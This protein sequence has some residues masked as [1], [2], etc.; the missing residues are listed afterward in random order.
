VRHPAAAPVGRLFSGEAELTEL[1][2]GQIE[3]TVRASEG[4]KEIGI[5]SHSRVVIHVAR[6]VRRLE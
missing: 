4:D 5:G 1:D 2:G 6:F 3:F